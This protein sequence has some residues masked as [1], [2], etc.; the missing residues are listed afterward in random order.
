[1][2]PNDKILVKVDLV[3]EDV[4]SFLIDLSKFKVVK[5]FNIKNSLSTT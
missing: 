4:D 2:K 5:L 3:G 1:M